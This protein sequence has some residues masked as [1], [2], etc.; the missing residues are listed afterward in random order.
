[1]EI[2]TLLEELENIFENARNIPFTNCICLNREEIL[3]IIEDIRLNLPDDLKQ[4]RWVKEE[5]Q[6]IL[7]DRKSVV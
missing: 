2:Y 1:M 5:R 3:Q 4:A 7:A 6:K